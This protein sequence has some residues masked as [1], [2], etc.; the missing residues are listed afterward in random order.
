MQIK[1]VDVIKG[2]HEA[3][4]HTS[5][6]WVAQV[7]VIGDKGQDTIAS[8]LNTPLGET[9]ELYIVIVEPLRITFPKRLTVNL[10]VVSCCL[11]HLGI[12][13]AQQIIDPLSLVGRVSRVGR[14]TQYYHNR[15]ALLHFCRFV[16]LI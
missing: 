3:L 10:K 8:L 4:A 13:T 6:G 12:F 11:T 16:G 2:L 14:I 7:P 15:I 9:D 5:K 1:N